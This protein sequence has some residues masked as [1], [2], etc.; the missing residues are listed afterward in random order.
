VLARPRRA[1]AK[2]ERMAVECISEVFCLFS[3]DRK[4]EDNFIHVSIGYLEQKEE[5]C[6]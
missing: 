1:A 3:V 2:T 4:G 5:E 6:A